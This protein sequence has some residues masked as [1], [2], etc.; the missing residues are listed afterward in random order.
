MM[1]S[2]KTFFSHLYQ[3]A[4]KTAR[5]FIRGTPHTFLRDVRR[6]VIHIGANV[7]QDR[8]RYAKHR[9]RVIWIEP[10]PS[11]FE[12]LRENIAGIPD[13]RAYRYLL[14]DRDDVEAPFHISNNDAKSSSILDLKRHREIWPTVD[15]VETITLVST[16]FRTFVEREGID[17]KLYDALVLDTQGAE[18][19][20]LKGAEPYLKGF[21]YIKC[22]V[23]DFEAYSGCCLV[24]EVDRFMAEHGFKKVRQDRF[25]GKEG[26]GNCYDA[27]Y[28]RVGR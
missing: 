6:G 12:R 28:R 14:T 4:R 27:L 19:L 23:S 13:Q 5:D 20:V 1:N 18:M 25:K 24:D 11:V 7:G 9:L 22:E 15:Y 26:V 16:T 2:D 17:L 21:R 10:I 8:G 3:R